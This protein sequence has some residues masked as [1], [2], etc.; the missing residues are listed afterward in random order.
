MTIFCS[1]RK[2]WV[3][4]TPEERVRQELLAYMLEQ[5]GFP[6]PLIVV[7]RKI[8]QL[9][10]LFTRPERFPNRRLDILCYGPNC[11]FPLLLIECKAHTF[12]PREERQVLGYNYYVGA[13]LV[14]LATR[15]EIRFLQPERRYESLPTYSDL[16]KNYLN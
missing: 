13:P 14:A 9:P 6:L 1:V 11:Q 10:H 4:D 2:E 8:S 15:G 3:V 5:Q 12:L 16:I 7:E